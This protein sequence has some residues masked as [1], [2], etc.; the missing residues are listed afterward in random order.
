MR[1]R[2]AVSVCALAV[3]CGACILPEDQHPQVALGVT[4]ASK[5]VHRGQTLV[6]RPVLQPSLSITS[7]T[8]D[9][10]GMRLGVDANMDLRNDTGSAWFPDGHA[11]RFTQIEFI[12]AYSRTFGDVTVE[13]GLHSYN[14]PNG[15]EF[16]LG[17]RGGT[18]ELFVTAS[19][20]VL[21]ATP[22]VSLH[23]D[24]DEVR[25][26]Y[27]RGGLTEDFELG[28]GWL[29]TLDGSLGY[30]ASSQAAWMYG[31]DES[32][33]ADLR[34]SAEVGWQYDPRTVLT[35]GLH[36][37]S[38]VDKTLRRWFVNDLGFDADPVWVSLGVAWQL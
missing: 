2:P 37:S 8:T 14:L 27:Y 15:L 32:G 19:A 35:F 20:N 13:G 10:G 29:L 3:V 28:E 7:P 17:E 31:L 22:Y 11:G 12:G 33:F 38:M 34:G 16:P 4:L 30:A 36:G 9:G 1:R 25:A 24:F 18:T 6:D 26:G 23:Y 21:E 5:A